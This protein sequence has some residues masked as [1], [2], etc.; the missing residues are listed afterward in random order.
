[1][2]MLRRFLLFILFLLVLAGALVFSAWHT[3]WGT[4]MLWRAALH[5]L[6]GNLSGTLAG[7]TLENGLRLHDLVYRDNAREVKIDQL[8]TRWHWSL[9]PRELTIA[10][11]R[12]GTIDY[13]QTSTS[14]QSATLPQQIVLPLPI[15]L[16]E[17]TVKKLQ[18]HRAGSTTAIDDIA[19]SAQSDGVHHTLTLEHATTPWGVADARLQLDGKRPFAT[20]GNANLH[21]SWRDE[22][23][24]LETT[25]AGTLQAL[26][27]QLRATGDKLSGQAHVEATPFAAVPLHRAQVTVHALNPQAF[28]ASAPQAVLDIE[29]ALAPLE[30]GNTGKAATNDSE[31]TLTG[32]VTIRNAQPGTIDRG[33]LPLVSAR[34][35]VRID[36]HQ[37]QLQQLQANL[38]GGATLEGSGELQTGGTGHFNL[39]AKALDLHALHA[40]L[41]PTTL[42]GPLDFELANGTQHIALKLQGNALAMNADA[43]IDAAQVKLNDA[44]LQAGSARLRMSGTMARTGERAYNMHGSLDDFNPAMFVADKAADARINMDF[45]AQG[46]LQPELNAKLRFDIRD[47]TY[48][49][50]PMTGNGKLNLV[51]KRIEDSNVQLSIAA[52]RLLLA[53]SFGKPGE[54]LKFN[55]DAPALA[56]LGYGLSGQLQAAGELGGSVERPAVAA[57]FRASQLLFR[58]YHVASLGGQ[59]DTRGVPG[60]QPD[61]HVTLKLDA[62]DVQAEDIRIA[63]LDAAIDGSY[64]DHAITA[65]V[66]GQLRGRPL[67]LTL[68]ARGNL[69]EQA[70]G[71]A[72]NGTVRTLENRGFPRLALNAPLEVSVA[73]KSVVLGA[74]HLTLE[75]ARVD[76]KGFRLDDKLISSEG[77]FSA[78][79]VRQLLELRREIT[80]AAPPVSTD[81]VL[82]GSW[83]FSLADTANGF[84]EIVRR[85]G[86]VKVLGGPRESALGLNALRLRGDLQGREIRLDAQAAASRIG[87]LAATGR[88][89]LQ[90]LD[91]RLMP[92]SD[93]AVDGRI[94]ASIPQLQ[95]IASLAGP[96]VALDG[97]IS[98]DLAVNGT[99][100]APVVSGDAS[101]TKLALTLY[102]QGVR[103]RDGSA[104]LHLD[105]NIVEIR[106]LVLHGSEGVVRAT[107]RLPLEPG[108]PDLSAIIIADHLQL[109][110][111]PARQLML[112]GQASA[113]NVGGRLQV[114]GKFTVDS[115]RF[116]LPEKSAP[117]LSD[118]VV[119]IR[120]KE[121]VALKPGA[122]PAAAAKGKAGPFTPAASID[123]DLGDDFRFTGSGADMLLGG[124]LNVKSEPGQAPQAFG[125]VRI[126]KGTYEAFGTKL[127]VEHGVINFQGPLANPNVDILAMRRQQDVAAGVQVTGTVRQP[128]VQLVSDPE[129]PD[130]EKLNWL[131]FGRSGDTADAGTG[132]AQSAAKD[133]AL[134][135]LNKFGGSRIAKGFGLDKLSI[136]SSEYGLGTQQVVSL[137]KEISNR[138]VVG[139]EQSLTGA[140][141][142]LKL[143]YELSRHWSIVLRGGAIGG[144][145]VSYSKR[146]DRFGGDAGS[147]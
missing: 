54:R 142:V 85:S 31:L 12:I 13:T 64:A 26:D 119:V 29:A 16:R 68:A 36:A 122:A 3:E 112:S 84:F 109:L 108:S 118:D 94:K 117:Q 27:I 77:A 61:A 86:D 20:N 17:A 128:R 101:A 143:T 39:Q 24:R 134:G 147:R 116:Q 55:I 37:Q 135:L 49:G 97:S 125:T 131:V 69:R 7:G 8:A 34:A 75:Q 50:L 53:G 79:D 105:N 2:L 89:A 121:K 1:M 45:D 52:N 33:L 66:N 132:Q 144:M 58:Q 18:L 15:D 126:V 141:G 60:R 100:A 93:S 146:F 145:D 78:L 56:R 9:S 72:W 80:G 32:P 22:A 115:A 6:P 74:T 127:D 5:A 95:R 43:L 87:D 130:Q 25:L 139:Y 63:T 47:S 67:A 73:P 137:G 99:L 104:Q 106:Q 96:S 83:N 129:V 102:D 82:D 28:V 23:Y 21:G 91:G 107:G 71:Y 123:I 90:P 124:A 62:R 120:G 30:N 110:A 59:V 70:Q 4:R 111:D 76:L 40:K 35:D 88:I 51:G 114:D 136:G 46:V 65:N 92:A 38:F 113:A 14:K 41:K 44:Q 57:T 138:L 140:E 103:L 19:L 11:L 48:A 133:A 98:A 10:E 42:D 81:L